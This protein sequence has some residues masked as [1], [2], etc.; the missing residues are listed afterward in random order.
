MSLLKLILFTASSG[1]SK[2][3]AVPRSKVSVPVMVLE[4]STENG[5]WWEG[6]S[7]AHPPPADIPETATMGLN[8]GGAWS[9]LFLAL[10]QNALSQTEGARALLSGHQQ[11]PAGLCRRSAAASVSRHTGG[12]SICSLPSIK[13]GNATAWQGDHFLSPCVI[14]QITVHFGAQ[15]CKTVIWPR[16]S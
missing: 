8:H 5:R 4:G 6:C 12:A 16:V 2:E 11:I 10:D 15:G 7:P 3:D 1:S 14:L 13:L 9:G